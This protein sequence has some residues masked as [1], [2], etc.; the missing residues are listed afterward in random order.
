MYAWNFWKGSSVV[1]SVVVVAAVLL[2]NGYTYIVYCL[3]DVWYHCDINK[4]TGIN[5]KGIPQMKNS[6][7]NMMHEITNHRYANF[8]K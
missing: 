5:V 3:F 4:A 7:F 2:L 6:L 8:A 1:V